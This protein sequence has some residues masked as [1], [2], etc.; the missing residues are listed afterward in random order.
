MN[1]LSMTSTTPSLTMKASDMSFMEQLQSQK[2]DKT[3]PRTYPDDIKNLES[4]EE[5]AL[6]F[7][8]VFL[9]EMMKPLFESIDVDP[10][11]G[12][13]RGEEIYRSMM[14]QEYGK[15]IAEHKSIG[16]ADYVKNELIRIQEEANNGK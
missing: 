9:S 3:P 4:I 13:G 5:R 14:V 7:E 15:K 8:A 2:T 1:P 6:D 16:L 12:G 10:L 11:F